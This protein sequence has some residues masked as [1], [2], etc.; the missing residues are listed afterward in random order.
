MEVK[1]WPR[2]VLGQSGKNMSWGIIFIHH[3]CHST[4]IFSF[5][6]ISFHDTI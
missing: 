4:E 5:H 3:V 1:G 2:L 6:H